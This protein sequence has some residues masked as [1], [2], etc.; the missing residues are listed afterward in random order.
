MQK[1]IFLTVLVLL[2]ANASATQAVATADSYNAVA[3]FTSG[4]VD[5]EPVNRIDSAK[6]SQDYIVLYV[7]W[8]N[9]GLRAHRTEVRIFDPNGEF[10]GKVRNTIGPG[11]G[12]F[13]TYYYYRPGP[14]D[15]PGDWTYKMFVDGRD[16]F[17]ARIPVLAA[18]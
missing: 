10:V 9:L 14:G 13:S 5:G 7:H 6:L 17:E 2:S 1:V 15:T 8:D 18:E 12:Q 16:A 3:Y 4:L 11:N